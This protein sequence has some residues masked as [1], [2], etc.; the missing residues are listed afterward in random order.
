MGIPLI[1]GREFTASDVDGAQKVAIVNEQFAKK[2][3]LGR[4]AVGKRMKTGSSGP[5]DLDIEIV[6]F[7]QNAKYSEVKQ[8][9][10]PLY[11]LPYRQNGMGSL[12][13]YVRGSSD[14]KNLFAMVPPVVAQADRNL[15][16]EDLQTMEQTVRN[17]VAVDRIITILSA[18]FASLATLLAAIGLY[19]VLAYTVAQRSREFGVRMAL[20]AAPS[21]VRGMILKQVGLM[22]VVGG[23]LGLAAAIGLGRLAQ[24]LLFEI[25]GYDATVLTASAM[26]LALVAFAAG[27]IPAHRA[28]KVDPMRALRYE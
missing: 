14:P 22:T 11:F 8:E 12:H 1:A 6:G 24:S 15:P 7:V 4:D 20:G 13:F 16:I 19:G 21:L 27:F 5:N 10:P 28:S 9:I 2:F 3:N 25:K 18:S 17:S 23:V 26:L